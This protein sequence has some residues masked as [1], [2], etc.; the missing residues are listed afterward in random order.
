M[1]LF[2]SVSSSQPRNNGFPAVYYNR[3]VQL[4]LGLDLD[5]IVCYVPFCIKLLSLSRILR[6]SQV[7]CVSSFLSLQGSLP[8]CGSMTIV[9]SSADKYLGCFQFG[10]LL[11]NMQ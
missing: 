10:F 11:I 9:Y 6:V 3:S 7:V 1:P 5:R 8:L 2:Q 4:V